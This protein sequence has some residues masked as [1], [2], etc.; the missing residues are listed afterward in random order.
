MSERDLTRNRDEADQTQCPSSTLRIEADFDQ[1]FRLV[2]LHQIPG[3]QGAEIAD[4]QPP[5]TGRAQRSNESPI[6][7]SPPG[8]REALGRRCDRARRIAVWLQAEIGR[9]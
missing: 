4:R 2:D 3:E 5:E 9:P 6:D 1:V 8:S 7:C